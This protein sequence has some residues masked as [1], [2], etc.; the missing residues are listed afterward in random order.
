MHLTEIQ[1]KTITYL[2]QDMAL[3][4]PLI[5]NICCASGLL[6]ADAR[7]IKYIR[8]LLQLKAHNRAFHKKYLTF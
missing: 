4:D 3:T 5:A 8:K 7:K 6:E 1:I 2:S